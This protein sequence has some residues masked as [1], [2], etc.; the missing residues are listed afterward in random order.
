MTI[1][2][3]IAAAIVLARGVV[4]LNHMCPRTG[5]PIR[6]TWLLLTVA[7]AAVL[8]VGARP[9]WP[10]LALHIGIAA[11]VCIGPRGLIF[12]STGDKP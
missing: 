2:N 1:L 7:A 9:T 6:A 12:C 8:L 11:L 4:A 10:E 5:L 3:L